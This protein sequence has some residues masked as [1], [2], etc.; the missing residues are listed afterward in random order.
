ML[1][2]QLAV[3]IGHRTPEQ[4]LTH[5]AHSLEYLHRQAMRRASEYT[6]AITP[7]VAPIT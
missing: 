4:T 7:W 2:Y 6:R 5:Y 3:W 1:L